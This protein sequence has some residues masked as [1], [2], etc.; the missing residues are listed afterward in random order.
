MHP[1]LLEPLCI[2]G[3]SAP[4]NGVEQGFFRMRVERVVSVGLLI[5]KTKPSA[6]RE[7]EVGKSAVNVFK[8]E[9]PSLGF[10]GHG[11]GC[12]RGDEKLGEQPNPR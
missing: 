4:V 10:S 12:F 2:P 11:K 1:F 5:R 8:E 6:F 9:L 3:A 7:P